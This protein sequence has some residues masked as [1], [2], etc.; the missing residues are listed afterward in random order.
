MTAHADK[1][2]LELLA[3]GVALARHGLGEVTSR[4]IGKRC[5]VAHTA[6]FYYFPTIDELRSAVVRHALET[7][8]APAIARL[9]LDGHPSIAGFDSGQRSA[10]L[11][12]AA[13]T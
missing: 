1:R 12:R 9:I 11:S 3:A 8:D 2:R 6:V 4:S 13:R 10:I 7:D 5:H